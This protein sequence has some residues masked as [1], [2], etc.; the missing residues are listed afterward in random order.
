MVAESIR[1]LLLGFGILLG[2]FTGSA[3]MAEPT[4][5]PHSAA[6][7][8]MAHTQLAEATAA[9]EA[10]TSECDRMRE[11]LAAELLSSVDATDDDLRTS[12]AYFSIRADNLCVKNEAAQFVVATL[13]L[14][15]QLKENGGETTHSSMT[16]LVMESLHTEI[17]WTVRYQALPSELR[18]E[19]ESI[20][21][22]KKPFDLIGT[23]RALELY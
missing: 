19:L 20:N 21:R 2:L 14:E 12:L 15:E 10:R 18:R 5:A 11:P 4:N 16:A 13:L 1:R 3:G 17:E 7:V 23:A 6:T 8:M 9:L 22:L